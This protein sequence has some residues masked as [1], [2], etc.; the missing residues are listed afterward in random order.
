MDTPLDSWEQDV[1]FGEP[2]ESGYGSGFQDLALADPELSVPLA[3]AL[4]PAVS[5]IPLENG[6]SAGAPEDVVAEEV[7]LAD[8]LCCGRNRRGFQSRIR[9]LYEGLNKSRER[10]HVVG[11][12][13]HKQ[14]PTRRHIG[15]RE[16]RDK[17]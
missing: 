7:A 4:E 8:V 9:E 17:L 3:N 13:A 15:R 12:V 1:T 16:K 11:D 2:G 14:G 6:A 10:D 5:S